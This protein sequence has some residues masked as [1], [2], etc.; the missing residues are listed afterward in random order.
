MRYIVVALS[1][2]PRQPPAKLS[3]LAN[4]VFSH[5][6]LVGIPI[7]VMISRGEQSK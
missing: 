4:L 7:A 5:I 3:S 6:F 2:T 1:A